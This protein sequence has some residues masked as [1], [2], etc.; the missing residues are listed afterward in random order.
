MQQPLVK[1]KL[2]RF[3]DFTAESGK[4]YVYRVRVVLEDPNRP[5]DLRNEPNSRILDQAVTDRLATVAAADQDISKR[6]GKPFRTFFVKTDWS[7]ACTPVTIPKHEQYVGG[8]AT[9][10][11]RIPVFQGVEVE[12]TEA[13]GKLV[14]AVW[15]MPR[16]AEIPVEKTV[17]RGSFLD[18]TSK[19]DALHPLTLQIRTIEDYPFDTDAF[20][21]DLRGGEELMKDKPT[22]KEVK[23][24]QKEETVHFTPG[25][26]LV[27]DGDGNLQVC[28]EI[29]DAEEFRR[30]LFIEDQPGGTMPGGGM[31]M[32]G[33]SPDYGGMMDY[34]GGS[35]SSAGSGSRGGS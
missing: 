25:E 24:Q 19:A 18:F 21:I 11:K 35:G 28:N 33:A 29:A 9:A 17:N 32:P 10:G 27:V 31:G 3:F 20:V 16:A 4:T 1:Y 12:T 2:V 22:D 6:T 26:F 34:F 8:S 23:E 7:A 15:D 13:E 5:V 30:L 14:A